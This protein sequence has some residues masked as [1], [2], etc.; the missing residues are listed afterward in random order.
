MTTVEVRPLRRMRTISTVVIVITVAFVGTFGLVSGADAWWQVA[1][2]APSIVVA[3]W[4]TSRWERPRGRAATVAALAVTWA[5]WLVGAL[6]DAGASAATPF[7]AVGA[8]VITTHP[9]WQRAGAF[10]LA[11]VVAATGWLG[12]LGHPDTTGNYVILSLV[13]TAIFVSTFWLNAVGWRLFTELDAMRASAAELAVI[14]ERMRFA[15][16]LHDIQGHTLH[17]IKLKA[18]VAA[19]VQQTDPDRVAAELADIERLTAETIEQAQQL[20][21]STRRLSL[22]AELANATALL[23][24]AGIAVNVDDTR[25]ADSDGDETFALVLREATTNILRHPSATRASIV[26][27]PSSLQI[28][29]DGAPTTIRPLRGLAA[30]R[31]RVG[32]AGGSL[33]IQHS[34]GDF[35]LHAMGS[36]A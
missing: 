13:Y 20:V 29:N 25:P 23:T 9:Q 15:A 34:D 14:K 26:L 2:L 1:L 33:D 18:A 35:R 27:S 28:T 8:I 21:N 32:H 16:D 3:T 31:E 11:L 22:T 19:K 30:L 5:S 36:R 17:V 10:G 7:V 6:V 24:A 4:F 12:T